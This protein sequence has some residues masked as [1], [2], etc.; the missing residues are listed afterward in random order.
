M[1]FFSLELMLLSGKAEKSDFDRVLRLS[2]S[3]PVGETRVSGCCDQSGLIRCE[4]P[5]VSSLGVIGVHRSAC[6]L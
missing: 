1:S 6:H 4:T 5:P 2:A 3:A